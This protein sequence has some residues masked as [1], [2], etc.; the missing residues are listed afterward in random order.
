M[1]K[2]HKGEEIW[3]ITFETIT[4]PIAIIIINSTAIVDI[5]LYKKVAKW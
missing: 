5:C 4:I 3:Y 1:A 2:D